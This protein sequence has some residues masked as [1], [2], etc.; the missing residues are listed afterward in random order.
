MSVKKCFK[1]KD[2]L[3]LANSLR[4]VLVEG[5]EDGGMY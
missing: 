2:L 1:R 3:K 5:R 4:I